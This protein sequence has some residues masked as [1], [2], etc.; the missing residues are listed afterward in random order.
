MNGAKAMFARFERWWPVLVLGHRWKFLIAAL[1]V[2]AAA[3]GGARLLVFDTNYRIF[4]SDSNPELKTL[5]SFEDTYT[6]PDNILIV[7]QP[8]DGDVFTPKTLGLIEHLS[9]EAWKIPTRSAWIQSPI[10]RTPGRTATHWSS[11]TWCP[12]PDSCP[13][14]S[15]PGSVNGHFPSLF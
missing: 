13:R 14:T 4:F 3:G 7:V 15:S 9:E 12:V 1:L 11:K 2:V 10:S 6:Q 5:D 8:P